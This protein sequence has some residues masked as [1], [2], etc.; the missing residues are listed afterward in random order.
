MRA[1]LV[2]RSRTRPTRGRGI[3]ILI[4]FLILLPAVSVM[5]AGGD[6]KL[7]PAEHPSNRQIAD[8]LHSAS[9]YFTENRGQVDDGVLFY[10]RGNPSV[11]FRTDGLMFVVSEAKN[12]DER[13]GGRVRVDSLAYTVRFEN[14][15]AITPVGLDELPFHSNYF[16]GEDP[17][18][19]QTDVPNYGSVIYR[20]LWN[21][22]DLVYRARSDGVKYEFLVSARA[23]PNLIRFSYQGVQATRN[24]D[25]GITTS[26]AVGDIHDSKP[27]SY[28]A[29]GR[30]VGCSFAERGGGSFGFDCTGWERSEPFVIDPLVYSTFLG[31]SDDNPYCGM[32]QGDE[33]V[34][35]AVDAAGN[36]F[37]YGA[38]CSTDFPVTVGAFN[39]TYWIRGTPHMVQPK[40]TLPCDCPQGAWC[41]DP[42]QAFVAKLN[43]EGSSL[44]YATYLGG[45]RLDVPTSIAIDSA[46]NAYLTGATISTGLQ[47]GTQ[48]FPTTPG[49]FD[50]TLDAF[51]LRTGSCWCCSIVFWEGY[52]TKL[53][54]QGNGLVYSTFLG[55]DRYE[56]PWAVTVD[57]SGY[58]YVTGETNGTN[59]PTTFG[60]YDTTYNGL[61]TD[62]DAF[63]TKFNQAGNGLVYS[64]FLGGNGYDFGSSIAVDSS[65]NAYVAGSTDSTDFPT[66][67]GA[68][69]STANGYADAFVARFNP[70]G[71]KLDYSTLLGG[72]DR[73]WE[74]STAIDAG[75]NV[76]VSGTTKSP[77]FPTT[78]TAF[79]TTYIGREGFVTKLDPTMSSLVYSTFIG[80]NSDTDTVTA[81]TLDTLGNAYVTGQ[82]YSAD[83]PRTKDAFDT[84][85]SD[86]EGFMTKINASGTGLLYS[87]YLGG[88]NDID[89]GTSIAVDISGIAYVTGVT[90]SAD[91]PTTPNAFDRTLG[92][93]TDAFVFKLLPSIVTD[94]PDLLIASTDIILSPPG[95]AV[96]GT[97]VNVRAEVHNIGGTNATQVE[98]R[99]HDGVPPSPQIGTDQIIPLI[100]YFN[101]SSASVS[102]IPTTVGTHQICVIA[103][104]NNKIVEAYENNNQ[105]CTQIEILPSNPDLTLLSGDI[106][107][108]IPP[109]FTE[110]TQVRI[111]AKISNIGTLSSTATT[112]RFHDGVPPAGQIGTDQPLG[113]LGVGGSGSVSVLWD[114][115]RPGS[116]SIC[117]VVDPNNVVQEL[118]EGNNQACKQVGVRSAP[119]LRISQITIEPFPPLIDGTLSW[120]NVTPVNAGDTASG[121]FDLIIFDDA[122]GDMTPDSG[123]E[124]GVN[125]IPNLNGHS[126]V[127]SYFTWI[128]MPPGSQSICTYADWPDVVRESRENNN[129]AC[130]TVQ[131][132]ANVRPDYTPVQPQPPGPI[133]IGLSLSVQLS[134]IVENQ[135]NDTAADNAIL[136][137]HEGAAPPFATFVVPP[138]DPSADSTRFTATWFSPLTPGAYRIVAD[139]D[140]DGNLTEWN[141]DNNIYEWIIDV[142][143]GPTTSLVIGNPNYTL[144]V[145]Y[146]TSSTPLEFSVVD[147]GGSGVRSTKYRIDGGGWI[148]YPA[149]GQFTLSTE[150]AHSI[151]WH[152]E[153]NAGNI[154]TV[155]SAV[156]RVDNTPPVCTL[157]AGT[158]QYLG[159]YTFVDSN[160]PF[161]LS[162]SDGGILPVGL[163]RTE[164]RNDGGLW[165]TYFT[166]FTLQGIDGAKTIEFRSSDL[167]GNL[168]TAAGTFFLDQTP[169]STSIDPFSEDATTETVFVLDSLDDGCG[170][171]FTVYKVDN[172]NWTVYS[173]GFTV[174]EGERN[175]TYHA[176]DWL[177]NR[178]ADK[179]LHVHS[180]AQTTS[181]E[182]NYKPF[183]AAVFALV[184]TLVGLWSSTRKPWKGGKDKAAV[185]MAFVGVSLP[186]VLGEIATGII[187]QIT[188]EL[189]VPP[190]I[191]VGTAVD[192]AILVLGLLTV[193]VRTARHR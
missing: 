115:S 126:Q 79:R 53:N 108:S 50:R 159:A 158:P 31:G 112:V 186:F 161:N 83:F 142:V 144:A 36:A 73:E 92:N 78:P 27:Y 82:T 160:T 117:V 138:L 99:F 9:D 134:V 19:W 54:P 105:A 10:F 171:N 37:I 151:E 46:G 114:V 74:V 49:A 21:G 191:G 52:L 170:V 174:P 182:T 128:A 129:V 143:V 146:V 64:T 28:Q 150:G 15:H 34:S 179:V 59:F 175:I 189:S 141:E 98:V 178:E 154:E 29:D 102:W 7:S 57:S 131:V 167:L 101:K 95:Y 32:G 84:V 157:H 76:Y 14:A 4:A 120:I 109:P 44:V 104:P 169:P 43:P 122:D 22:I 71:M 181:E 63:V 136:A 55:A 97:L 41:V 1:T 135:G 67:L 38:T 65:G 165:L 162:C 80:G 24:P 18:K 11:A 124:I 155:D 42:R 111:D 70:N 81:I 60:A 183:I 93:E 8:A 127:L 137:F 47:P 35:I 132:N 145:P 94:P 39:T 58:A 23:D 106:T 116:H 113:P 173:G 96:V 192:L 193:V 172:G 148:N 26:T 188:G 17:A 12:I 130:T 118:N 176:V 190:V 88:S 77:N 163:D 187:S 152:S 139:V 153:D 2:S 48:A 62:A 184:L 75:K 68:Y 177:G 66:T 180:R 110:G 166:D 133:T 33:G 30:E 119:D 168:K 107:F 13:Y 156:L 87:T 69:D 125:S 5:R 123:E 86:R 147:T 149:N 45:D 100:R 40:C 91:F 85:F 72:S 3:S 140:F 20:N 61:D 89:K 25:E 185:A 51:S 6:V 103:D 164:Y 16:I 56:W 121:A 90:N